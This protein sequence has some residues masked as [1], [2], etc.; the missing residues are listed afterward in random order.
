[1]DS[2]SRWLGVKEVLRLLRDH[3]EAYK[4]PKYVP[5]KLE[6]LSV[7]MIF[8]AGVVA[9]TGEALRRGGG[10]LAP[11]LIILAFLLFAAG[12]LLIVVESIRTMRHPFLQ[13]IDRIPEAMDRD[14][15]LIDALARFDAVVLELARGRLSLESKKAASK[16]ELIGGGDG[17]RTSLVGIGTLGMAVIAAYEPIVNGWTLKSL[18]LI[19][20]SLLLG[21]SIGGLLLRHGFSQAEYYCEIIGMALQMKADQAKSVRIPFSRRIGRGKRSGY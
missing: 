13:F 9:V 3:S 11:S 6:R 15:A 1:M 10:L 14:S 4:R 2:S 7:S 16:L 19:G 5:T 18:A 8:M 17:L 21:L 12:A 20:A